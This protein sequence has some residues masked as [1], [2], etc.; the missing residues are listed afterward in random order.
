VAL[1]SLL[2]ALPILFMYDV[3]LTMTVLGI[4]VLIAMTI[5]LSLRPLR[6]RVMQAYAYNGVTVEHPCKRCLMAN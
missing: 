6:Q 2:M 5:G 1:V 4:G 3:T